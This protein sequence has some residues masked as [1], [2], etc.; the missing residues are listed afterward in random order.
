[1]PY[2]L[3]WTVCQTKIKTKYKRYKKRV[4]K[5]ASREKWPICSEKHAHYFWPINYHFQPQV[6]N[7]H[8]ALSER[9]FII[10]ARCQFI[11]AHLSARFLLAIS[12]EPSGKGLDRKRVTR[13]FF[14]L[15]LAIFHLVHWL[16]YS[17]RWQV[18]RQHHRRYIRFAARS[19]V[20]RQW[21][22]ILAMWRKRAEKVHKNK[23]INL[24]LIDR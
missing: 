23:S 21:C 10:T 13:H 19:S 22:S 24:D 9:Q 5:L 12:D 2:H 7:S 4:K 15:L 1:M 16:K 20:V 14:F 17:A 6:A 18:Q 8:C 3:I 11:Q